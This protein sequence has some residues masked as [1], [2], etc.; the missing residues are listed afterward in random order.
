MTGCSEL[1]N[2]L[3]GWIKGQ[4]FL[5]ELKDHGLIK[6]DSSPCSWLVS[7][8]YRFQ[9]NIWWTTLFILV[10]TAQYHLVL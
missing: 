3:P 5:V 4:E 8:R 10:F 1:G 6:E 7:G 9:T 2:K